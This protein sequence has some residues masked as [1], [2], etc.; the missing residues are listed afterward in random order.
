M[1][2]YEVPI[3]WE[4][5]PPAINHEYLPPTETPAP[6][7]EDF[8]RPF[9]F[10]MYDIETNPELEAAILDYSQYYLEPMEEP[11][12]LTEEEFCGQGYQ[13]LEEAVTR[14]KGDYKKRLREMFGIVLP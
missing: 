4:I 8:E 13:V 1:E 11:P 3:T 9:S 5:L 14:A 6:P 10:P 2:L 7:V 12:I